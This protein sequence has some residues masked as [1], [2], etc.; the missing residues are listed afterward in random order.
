M[1]SEELV[2]WMCKEGRRGKREMVQTEEEA[3]IQLSWLESI[4][5]G[6]L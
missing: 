2:D 1:P 6:C 3:K 4:C 5:K